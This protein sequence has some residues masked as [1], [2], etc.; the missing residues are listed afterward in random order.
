MGSLKGRQGFLE[1]SRAEEVLGPVPWWYLPLTEM[2]G[3]ASTRSGN[4]RR[5]AGE[6]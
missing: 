1:G 3:V 5:P 2:W 6:G 4:V